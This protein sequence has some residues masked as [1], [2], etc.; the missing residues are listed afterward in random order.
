MK[1]ERALLLCFKLA[2][3]ANSGGVVPQLLPYVLR[4][5]VMFVV[6]QSRR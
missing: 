1:Y 6:G 4:Q 5:L 2:R 3:L